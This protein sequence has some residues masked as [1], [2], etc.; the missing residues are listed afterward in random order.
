MKI[1]KVHHFWSWHFSISTISA[2]FSLWYYYNFRL[3]S[4]CN[5]GKDLSKNKGNN[6][7]VKHNNIELYLLL[8]ISINYEK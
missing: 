4:D 1:I 3:S 6:Q 7:L 2:D 5:L 8:Y